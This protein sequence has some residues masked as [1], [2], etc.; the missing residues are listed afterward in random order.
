MFLDRSIEVIF[1]LSD[2]KGFHDPFLK[3][4]RH[5]LKKPHG[6]YF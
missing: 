1:K 4:A 5:K 6:N 2:T 3:L